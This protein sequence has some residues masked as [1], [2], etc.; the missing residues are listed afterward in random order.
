MMTNNIENGINRWYDR[1]DYSDDD[2]NDNNNNNKI[3]RDD[4]ND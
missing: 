4:D 1:N 3:E 2:N